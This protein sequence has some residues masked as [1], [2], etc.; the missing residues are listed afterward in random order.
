MSIDT[1]AYIG[2]CW[3]CCINWTFGEN[4]IPVHVVGNSRDFK[5]IASAFTGYGLAFCPS[6][7][8]PASCSSKR[9]VHLGGETELQYKGINAPMFLQ[10][11]SAQAKEPLYCNYKCNLVHERK[12]ERIGATRQR[13]EEDNDMPK[14]TRK[15]WS[16]IKPRANWNKWHWLS[17]N[18]A[19]FPECFP[20]SFRG[21]KPTG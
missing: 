11:N 14:K 5:G 15:I 16:R 3:K 4:L 1:L 6:L 19:F 8:R 20:I 9:W 2:Q 10:G 7:H 12:K 13:S 21:W 18:Q 17:H